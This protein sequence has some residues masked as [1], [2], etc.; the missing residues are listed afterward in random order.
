MLVAWWKPMMASCGSICPGSAHWCLSRQRFEDVAADVVATQLVGVL[1]EVD[2]VSVVESEET[3]LSSSH[4]ET[5]PEWSQH[6]LN[7]NFQL[8]V[9]EVLCSVS[10]KLRAEKLTFQ[11]L[12]CVL[13]PAVPCLRVQQAPRAVRPLPVGI[14]L[15]GQRWR[16]QS[17]PPCE[18]LHPTRFQAMVMPTHAPRCHAHSNRMQLARLTAPEIL[19]QPSEVSVTR[20]DACAS[21][22]AVGSTKRYFPLKATVDASGKAVTGMYR[23]DGMV[24]ASSIASY[25]NHKPWQMIKIGGCTA[26]PACLRIMRGCA[27]SPPGCLQ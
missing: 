1:S 26:V 11:Q 24:P 27:A 10:F 16:L 8:A 19:P 2:V 15:T 3:G 22:S 25:K 12:Q 20:D 9:W 4:W 17:R 23:L 13:L 14:P 6:L 5:L 18:H 7:Y 21:S